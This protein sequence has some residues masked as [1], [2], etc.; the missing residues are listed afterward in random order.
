MKALG[1]A[2]VGA[3][4]IGTLRAAAV[5]RIPALR[6]THVADV[7]LQAAER[8]ARRSGAAAVSDIAAAVRDPGVDLVLVCTP[9]AAH[10]PAAFDAIAAGKHVLCEKPLAHQ[11]E[12]A[13]RLCTAAETRGVL[14]RTGFNHR[15]FPAMML[16]KQAIEDGRIG[17]V[18]S[19][20]AR[21]GHPG[22]KELGHAWVVD[23]AVTGGGSLV[24]NGI[25]ILDLTRFFLGEI[26][27][28]KG[29]V[30][31]L[32]WTAP[33]VEDNG[34]ALFRTATGAVAQVHAS[35]TEW[36]GYRFSIECVGTR[37]FVRA[38]YPPMLTV[39]GTLRG[40]GERAKKRYEIFPLLQVQERLRSW[41]W[42]IVRSFVAELRALVSDLGSGRTS[43]ATGR[44]GLRALQM[45]H[46]VYRSSQE[47]CEVRL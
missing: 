28:A 7:H 5:A 20:Q 43:T 45:A 33:A 29:Y 32:V 38:S 46:A 40:P 8:V 26:N 4:E 31:N 35:W 16:A 18:V 42:T 34:F 47:G 27:A 23:R 21:A 3:G 2:I 13:E 10:A 17:E 44:D 19:V 30:A 15:F 39:W 14:L 1:V 25:H 12:E 9:P 6:L 36:R 41:R 22:G 24:D 11:P 37:G